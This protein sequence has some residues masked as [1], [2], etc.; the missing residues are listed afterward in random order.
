MKS[1]EGSLGGWVL[2]AIGV[3]VIIQAAVGGAADRLLGYRKLYSGAGS[4]GAQPVIPSTC[5]TGCEPLRNVDPLKWIDCLKQCSAANPVPPPPGAT[6]Q[7][8]G[9]VVST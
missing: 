3:L 9:Q 4:T 5:M 7:H 1:G 6:P 8:T 2:I